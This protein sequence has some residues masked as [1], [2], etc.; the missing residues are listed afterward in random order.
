MSATCPECDGRGTFAAFVDGHRPDG[1]AWGEFRP[2]VQCFLCGGAGKIPEE[3]LK[4][5]AIGEAHRKARVKRMESIRE[6]A[7]RL[8]VSPSQLSA[9]EYGRLDPALLHQPKETRD[10]A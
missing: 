10:E 9:M 1:T 4:W 6:A 3:H 2:A 5:R 8:G 7:E